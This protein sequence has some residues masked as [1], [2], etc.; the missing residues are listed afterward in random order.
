MTVRPLSLAL[1][2]VLAGARTPASGQQSTTIVINQNTRFQTINGWE[3]TAYAAQVDTPSFPLY[4]DALADRAAEMGLNRVRLEVRSGVENT[5]P[6]WLQYRQ[7]LLNNQAWRCYR[8]STVNDN[9]NPLAVNPSGFHFDEMDTAVDSIV[10][11]LKQKLNARG[12]QLLINVNYVSFTSQMTEPGC[13]AGLQNHHASNP[14]EYA[15]FVLATYQHLQSKYGLIPDYWEM[16]L[17]PD[18]TAE[19]RGPQIGAA[20]VA[21]GQRLQANGFTPRFILPSNTNATAAVTY[22]DQ[23][24]QVAGVL[25]FTAELAY[26][27]YSGASTSTLQAIRDRGVQYGIRTAMLEHI[28]SGH[29]DLHQDLELAG[30]SSW[31]QFTLASLGLN[32]DGGSYFRID[33]TNPQAPQLVMGWRTKYL[34]QYFRYIRTGAVRVGASS[35]NPGQF[36]ALAFQNTDGKYAVVVKTTLGGSITVQGLP[37]GA[38]SIRYTTS[39]LYDAENP[40]VNL[41]AGQ[42]LQTSI[43]APGVITIFV[44]ASAPAGCD[45]NG[46]S[47]LSAVDI[48]LVINQALGAAACTNGDLDQS[49][50]CNVIDIQRVVNAVLGG[51]CRTGP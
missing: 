51:V 15:E 47:A 30:N 44:P 2:I 24:I 37:A 18:N 4:K 46:D 5:Q 43:P 27:R 26:H 17:E 9:S 12:Q 11:P 41:Q 36:D 34:R 40:A 22:F 28:G 31:A 1:A 16:I 49:G 8:Y 23:A 7:G 10:L 13:P 48:A 42:S 32:D 33:T 21:A 19:W 50:G 20:V 3:A 35:T 6:Y 14:Q 39:S 38:Y 45:L 25:P 29:E